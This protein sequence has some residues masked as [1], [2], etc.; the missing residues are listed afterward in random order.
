MGKARA[1]QSLTR[2]HSNVRLLAFPTNIRL[3]W[4]SVEIANTVAFYDA[5]TITA[6]IVAISL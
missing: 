4:L 2:L 3:G 5:E 6:I 1:Y